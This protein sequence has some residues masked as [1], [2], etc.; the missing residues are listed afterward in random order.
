MGGG[1]W[2]GFS[3]AQ[4]RH[5]YERAF[6]GYLRQRGVSFVAVDEARRALLPEAGR[7]AGGVGEAGSAVGGGGLGHVALDGERRP[8]KSFD[9]VAYAPGAT[10]G[11]AVPGRE[12]LLLELKGRKISRRVL[13]S[14]TA[15]GAVV[16]MPRTRLESWVTLDDIDSLRAWEM[17]FGEGFAAVVVFVYWCDEQP[18][19]A[20]FQEVFDYQGRWYAIR[21][22]FVGEYV[23]HMKTRSARWRT[24]DLPGKVFE[25]ISHPLGPT[26]L[27]SVG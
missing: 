17:L 11:T 24:V 14:R 13:S 7:S 2:L 5:H 26:W 3:V 9:F 27:G 22:V 10:G 19:D 15:Q 6:E 18:P 1:A 4:R 8:L 12:H 23:K 16:S 21:A 20:L 25:S